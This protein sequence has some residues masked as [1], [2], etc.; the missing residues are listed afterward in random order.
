MAR[1]VL[2][3]ANALKLSCNYLGL[4][5]RIERHAQ[6]RSTLVAQE[7]QDRDRLLAVIV[8]S[9][10]GLNEDIRS[11]IAFWARPTHDCLFRLLLSRPRLPFFQRRFD[12]PANGLWPCWEVR[13]I[14]PPIVQLSQRLR[15][16][17]HSH[18]CAVDVRSATPSFFDVIYS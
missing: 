17:S 18:R 2:W 12:Q 15:E 16:Y 3:V 11:C 1:G 5:F 13:L 8:A 4:P 14:P 6:D 7:Y 9:T 10:K